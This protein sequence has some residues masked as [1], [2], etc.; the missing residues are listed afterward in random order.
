MSTPDLSVTEGSQGLEVENLRKSYKTR[1]VIR[2]F[3]MSLNRG[4]VVALLGP[5]GCG[6][7]TTFYSIAGLVYPEGGHVKIDGRDVTGLPMYRRAKLGIGYLPQE[8]S[9]FRGLSVED[10]IASILDISEK[11]RHK[12]RERLEELLSEF[13]IE[14]LRRAP[15]LALSGG[16]RRRVEIARCLAANPKYLLLDEP[17]AGV[18][19]I[20]VGD[21]R[22]L[23]ADLKKRGIGVL[24]TDHNVRETLEIV[25]RAYILHDGKVLMSGTPEE[26]VENENVRRV[27]LGDNF[28]IT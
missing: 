2:D 1:V 9:I 11:S 26:V 4:E 27:Y 12:R 20:S 28:K 13:S 7:S 14:H 6:K 17:F 25:D 21:I 22:H 15:A 23:V 16:E 24:I 19:P 10:N 18:D 3:S 5:N 8:M